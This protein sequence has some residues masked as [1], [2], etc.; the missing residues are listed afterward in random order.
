MSVEED[1]LNLERQEIARVYGRCDDDSIRRFINEGRAARFCDDY[2]KKH[3]ISS[4]SDE[5]G[6]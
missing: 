3:H 5:V 6:C 2:K 1:Y 4:L